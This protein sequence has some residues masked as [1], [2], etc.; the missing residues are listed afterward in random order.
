LKL[1]MVA[2]D[3]PTRAKA[4]AMDDEQARLWNGVAARGWIETRGLIDQVFEPMADLLLEVVPPGS[5]Y[6]VL[7]VGCGTGATTLASARRLGSGGRALGVDL[8][9]PMVDVARARAERDGSSAT[10]LCADAQSYAFEPASFDVIL[11]RFGVMFFNDAVQAFANL[12]GAARSGAELR[13]V[14][15]RGPEENAFMTTAERAA[16]PLLQDLPVRRSDGPGQFAFADAQRVQRILE[17]SGWVG[18]EIRPVDVACT[19][20]EGELIGYFTRLGPLSRVLHETDEQTRGQIIE[21]VRRAF[22]PYV[23]GTQVRF[24]AACWLVAARP[25]SYVTIES[26]P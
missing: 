15:W 26:A 7:D 19:F 2:Q 4:A 1:Q 11:S 8:S 13:C 3:A 22:E 24:T 12:R 18:I 5:E 6:A 17:E 25:G 9:A 16:A 14:V 10:F 21:T 20:A 23:Q